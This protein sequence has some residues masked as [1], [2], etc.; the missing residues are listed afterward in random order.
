MRCSANVRTSIG[1]CLFKLNRHKK[2]KIAYERARQLDHQC[3][4]AMVG[5]ALILF[6]RR[7]YRVGSCRYAAAKAKIWAHTVEPESGRTKEL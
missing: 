7:N 1:H 2:A 5:L 3:V 4:G 6:E